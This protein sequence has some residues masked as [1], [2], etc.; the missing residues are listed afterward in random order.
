MYHAA[1][2]GRTPPRAG[3]DHATIAPYGEY[4]CGDGRHVFLSIQ[5]DREWRRFCASVLG[6]ASLADDSRY[7]DNPCRVAHRHELRSAIEAVFL[8]LDSGAVKERLERAGIA[9]ADLRSV[10][11]LA[12][13]PQLVARGRLASVPSFAGDIEAF[14][15]PFNIVELTPTMG[16]IPAVGEH[17]GQV[18]REVGLTDAEIAEIRSG[19]AG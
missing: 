19:R 10:A 8:A 15:P 5:N 11:E 4:A 1:A 13:H 18:L 3:T 9:Y 16:K 17:T 2:G 14:L 7:V 12:S 6:R